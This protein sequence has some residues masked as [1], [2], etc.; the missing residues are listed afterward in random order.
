MEGLLLK[1][2]LQLCLA[3]AART[4]LS[5]AL[6]VNKT[7]RLWRCPGWYLS[8]CGRWISTQKQLC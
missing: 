7:R 4:S 3:L 6:H 5:P 2:S 1:D 8:H